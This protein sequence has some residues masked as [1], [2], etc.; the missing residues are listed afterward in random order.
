MLEKNIESKMKYFCERNGGQFLKLFI[1]D[2]NG[3]PDRLMLMPNG[4]AVFIEMKMKGKRP[5][6][7]QIYQHRKLRQLGFDV[8]I[9]DDVHVAEKVVEMY[10]D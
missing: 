6:K 7:L 2:E 9:V 3:I 5:R 8:H 4:Q 1:P 10:V